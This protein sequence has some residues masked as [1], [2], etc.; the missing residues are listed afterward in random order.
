MNELVKASYL[1]PMCPSYEETVLAVALP[2]ITR[3]IPALLSSGT[4]YLAKSEDGR[5]VGCGGWTWERPGSGEVAPELAHVRH[6]FTRPE[7]VGRGI[8]RVIYAKCEEEA[9]PAGVRRFECHS[10]LNA[11]GFYAALGFMSVSQM[12]IG[13]NVKLSAVLMERSI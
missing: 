1:V 9:R 8:G 12:E 2:L 10:S 13:R 7:W 5:I 4:Y 6:F 3:T 11:E